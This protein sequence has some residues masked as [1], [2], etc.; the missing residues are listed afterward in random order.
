MG[1]TIIA[2]DYYHLSVLWALLGVGL[3]AVLWHHPRRLKRTTGA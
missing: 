2:V 1:L 3:L